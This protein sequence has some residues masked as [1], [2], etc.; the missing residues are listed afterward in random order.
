[1]TPPNLSLIYIMVLFWLTYW[2]VK[3]FLVVPVGKI[4]DER[5][6][7]VEGTEATAL[8]TQG[9]AVAATERLENELEEAARAASKIRAEHRQQAQ[10]ARQRQHD[11]VRADADVRLAAA[12][13]ELDGE[14]DA[15]SQ[16]LHLKARELARQF[17]GKLLE[18]EMAS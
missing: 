9:D 16:Q 14:A 2:L 17:A 11:E 13:S 4:L 5:F 18:R 15:A 12:L 8:A 7:R 3:R 10:A 6:A 1:M